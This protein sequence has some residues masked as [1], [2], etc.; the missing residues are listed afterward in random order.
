MADDRVHG[1]EIKSDKDR[2]DRLP[3]QIRM[4]SEALDAVT[5]VVGWRHVI[6]SMQMIPEWWGVQL[7]EADGEEGVRL[8][9]LREP[10]PNPGANPIAVASLLWRQ[11][12]LA[13]LDTHGGAD[14]VR[15]KPRAVVYSRLA[16]LVPLSR[17]RQ[18]VLE[19]LKNREGWRCCE[20]S[21]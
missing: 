15:S 5:L 2:L 19:N 6:P 4:F 10:L 20:Q 3:G 12:A 7:A 16:G 8:T 9:E 11:E 18:V 13:V 21:G 17:L 1:Y 14:G